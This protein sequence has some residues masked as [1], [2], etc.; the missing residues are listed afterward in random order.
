MQLHVGR[1]ITNFY[2]AEHDPLSNEILVAG[3]YDIKT[4]PPPFPKNPARASVSMNPNLARTQRFAS[5]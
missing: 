3:G 5:T 2:R 1:A 4:V